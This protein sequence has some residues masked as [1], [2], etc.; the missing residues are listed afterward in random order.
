MIRYH[1]NITIDGQAVPAEYTN[2]RDSSFFNEGKWK[3]FIVKFLPKDPTDMTFVEIG[4]NVGLYLKMASDYGFRNVVGVEAGEANC[5]MAERY[6]DA[7][8]Y[9]YKVLH[10]TVGKDFDFDEIPVADVVLLSNVH[11]YIHMEHFV[12]FLDQLRNKCI[13]CIVVSRQMKD[14]RHGSPQPEADA[15]RHMFRDWS[16]ERIQFTSSNMLKGDPH[17]RRPHSLLF[18]SQLQRQSIKD[19]TTRTQKYVLQ[20]EWIDLIRAGREVVL[21]NTQNW[22][23]WKKRKQTDKETPRFRWTDDQIREHVQKR[24]DLVRSIMED[25]VRV[26]LY[27]KPHRECIDGGNRAAILK[28]LGYNSVIVRII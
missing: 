8:G 12:P 20:Q 2:R 7:G 17:P 6:R 1:Q 26:P 28:L 23:Y 15:I 22:A 16:C 14:K 3:N 13:N 19:Y 25:G 27:V 21:E 4:C 18:R 9:D 24:Y 5:A 11:Y 10:R